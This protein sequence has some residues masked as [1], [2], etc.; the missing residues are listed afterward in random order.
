[1]GVA[2]STLKT[3]VEEQREDL[4]AFLKT[5]R[6]IRRDCQE[7]YASDFRSRLVS[8]VLG[9]RRSGKSTLCLRELD[10]DTASYLNF[11]D[12]RLLGVSSEDL[13]R[14]YEVFL[15]V[16]PS[17]QT[18]VLDEAQNVLGWELFVNRLQRK[19]LKV[20]VT[21]SNAHLLGSELS[22]HLT[23]RVLSTELF[24][25]SF[26]E[27]IRFHGLDVPK[28][29]TA[30]SRSAFKE[31]LETYVDSGGFP[32]VVQGERPGPYLRELFDR[33]VSRDVLQRRALKSSK[34]LK[35]LA[36]YVVQTSGSLVSYQKLA[37]TFD[38]KSV[39]TVKRYL[40][41]LEEAYLVQEVLAY[42][43][44]LKERV[45]LPRKYYAI[46]AGLIRSLRVK[47]TQDRGS[48]LETLVFLQLRRQ[49]R[50]LYHYRTPAADVDFVVCEGGKP[51]LLVQACWS[52]RDESTRAR[53]IKSLL[54]AG[55]LLRTSRHILVTWDEEETIEVGK[56]VI[57]VVP[58]WKFLSGQGA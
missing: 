10:L 51:S 57:R 50:E 11:D 25:F 49:T 18:I 41:F 3:V 35:E 16:N 5:A 34:A 2:T 45:T 55:K 8:V 19:G 36:L 47:P 24:P 17:T 1:M 7:A 53:E 38:F 23:G 15:Q 22:T 32:E 44:K 29:W 48:E 40:G 37:R 46:D 56:K 39:H 54:A 4:K 14:L 52:L 33:I 30:E 28:V 27:F 21:G 58:V 13:T 31:K 6:L 20:V 42:S 12:E 43:N 9:V 26:L